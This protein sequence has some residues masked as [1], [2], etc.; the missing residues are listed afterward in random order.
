MGREKPHRLTISI[1]EDHYDAVE[2]LSKDR[3]VSRSWIIREAIR[4]Y[5]QADSPLSNE[6]SE[7]ERANDTY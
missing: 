7:S 1:P 5:V 4:E 2:R 3:R 6:I